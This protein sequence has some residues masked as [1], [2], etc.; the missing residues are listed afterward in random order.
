MAVDMVNSLLGKC[1]KLTYAT[2]A[3]S[4]STPTTPRQ[5]GTTSP[6]EQTPPTTTSA[7]QLFSSAIN[8]PTILESSLS[9]SPSPPPEI[10]ASC[11]KEGIDECHAN[12]FLFRET[13]IVLR[14]CTTCDL[15]KYCSGDKC[16]KNHRQHEKACKKRAAEI[17]RDDKLFRQPDES[18]LVEC[19]ICCLPL[20]PDMTK[21]VVNSCCCKRICDGCDYANKFCERKQG[22]GYKCPYCRETPPKMD[23]EIDQNYIRRIKGNDP[24]ALL[25]EMGNKCYGEGDYKGAFEYMAKAAQSG[26]IE[27]HYRLGN[28][29]R[30]GRGVEKDVE[31][32]VY[33]WEEAAIGG[34]LRARHNLGC[35]EERN[36]RFDRAVKHFIVAVKLGNQNSLSYLKRLYA[37]AE[38]HAS[39]EDYDAAVRACRAAKARKKRAAEIRDDK[40]FRQPDESHLGECPICCLPLPLDHTKSFMKSCCSKRICKGCSYAN[41]KRENEAGL[42][43]RCPFCREPVAKSKEGHDKNRM[44]RVK[45]NDP[46]ALNQLGKRCIDDGDYETS[47]E[48][49]AKAAGLGDADAHHTLSNMYY[50]GQ[51]VEEDM[52]KRVYHAEQ[53]AI[54]GHPWARHNLGYIEEHNGRFERA[55][56][57][58]IIAAKL[59]YEDSLKDLRKLYADG[60]ARKE[61]Y[62][63]ALRAYQAAVEETKSAQREEAEAYYR[64]KG[65]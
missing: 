43:N 33:H 30:L 54:A 48:Y 29:Y 8:S 51:F 2:I 5:H 6:G 1:Q 46:A 49:L 11:G 60:H 37:E 23:E 14:K 4:N 35:Y 15:V 41:K 3:A 7:T 26:N 44:K 65:K 24:V 34:H 31:K 38:G 56:K 63:D 12:A 52:K 50:S 17:I 53:A 19:Q 21:S 20:P 10:C 58:L 57:H 27:A 45:K 42:T 39:K 16:Q 22:Q 61:D 25:Q 55:K 40:L 13:I 18:H 64:A 59:G 62:S 28:M 9:V 36:G 32:M 47:F